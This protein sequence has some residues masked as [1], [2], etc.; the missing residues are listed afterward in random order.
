MQL[1]LGSTRRRHLS[2]S[3]TTHAALRSCKV[4]SASLAIFTLASPLGTAW[5]Q[6]RCAGIKLK[7]A[8]KNAKC[9][10]NLDAK[11][12]KSGTATD[13][14]KEQ[15]CKNNLGASF[16]A[17]EAKGGCL[18]TGDAQQI[19]DKTDA[20][21]ADVKSELVFAL[22]NGCQSAKIKAAGRTAACLLGLASREASS[23]DQ[24]SPN[25]VQRCKDTLAAIFSRSE[26]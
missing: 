12:A 6:N 16:G 18:T 5:A 22:P 15:R 4:L 9:L 25:K 21:R 3:L 8:S 20:F 2:C 23:G 19:E 26:A 17:A 7:A 14:A 24:P 1:R 11:S 10:V 13:P